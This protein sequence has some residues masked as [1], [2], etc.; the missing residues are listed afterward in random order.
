MRIY[1]DALEMIKEVERDL[2]EMGIRYQS[3]TVQDKDVSSDPGYETLELQGY[4][5]KLA[6]TGVHGEYANLEAM[7]KYNKEPEFVNWARA[8]AH[9]RVDG[10]SKN[11]GEAWKR[12]AEFWKPFLRN[13][14]FS[15]T[16]SERW[17][18]QFDYVFHELRQRPN[19]RQ[20]VITMYDRHQDMMNW[21]GID[22]VPCSLSYQFL[23]RQGALHVIYT[24]RSCDFV[25]FFQADVYCTITLLCNMANELGV[26]FGSLTHFIG[27]LHAFKKDLAG[28]F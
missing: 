18:E 20:A 24:M 4:A 26:E 22:R 21:G 11:P 23:I 19:T 14:Q 2:F 16:Y 10:L 17:T 5:Y 9:E 25:N 1:Q 13:G 12:R 15:Y 6:P 28:V 27:S 3:D 8:E 7:L